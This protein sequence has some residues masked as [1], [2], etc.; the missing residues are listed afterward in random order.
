MRL[1]S[2]IR[3]ETHNGWEQ[4]QPHDRDPSY[5]GQYWISTLPPDGI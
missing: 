5:P 2:L 4:D 1:N 3:L